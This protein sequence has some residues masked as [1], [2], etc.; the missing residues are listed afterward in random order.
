MVLPRA[1][2]WWGLLLVIELAGRPRFVPDHAPG[3]AVESRAHALLAADR[4]ADMP[5]MG[6][7]WGPRLM[8][9]GL[10]VELARTILVDLTSSTAAVGAYAAA[11]LT[12]IRERV[13]DR[14]DPTDRGSPGAVPAAGPSH[15]RPRTALPAS[16]P[17]L[18]WT[19]RRPA[20]PTR[21]A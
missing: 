15:V 17:R 11:N 16:T 8:R 19:A 12:R 2:A 20:P 7:D 10:V 14:L 3:G 9:A 6:S 21:P 4:T 5:T 18:P 13:G 1:S